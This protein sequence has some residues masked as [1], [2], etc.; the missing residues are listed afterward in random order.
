MIDR[1]I[2]KCPN[3][4]NVISLIRLK[5]II[6]GVSKDKKETKIGLWLAL[7]MSFFICL[8]IVIDWYCK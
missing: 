7:A 5:N 3:V 8:S 1:F 6:E 2:N 4:G